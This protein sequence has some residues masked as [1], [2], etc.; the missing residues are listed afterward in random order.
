MKHPCLCFKHCFKHISWCD[1]FI[2]CI[3]RF[4]DDLV[5][6]HLRT[7]RVTPC[8]KRR[9]IHKLVLYTVNF[10][11]SIFLVLVF[12]YTL[13][14]RRKELSFN[15]EKKKLILKKNYKWHREFANAYNYK[16]SYKGKNIENSPNIV[17]LRDRDSML[18][19]I[20]NPIA[21]AWVFSDSFCSHFIGRGFPSRSNIWTKLRRNTAHYLAWFVKSRKLL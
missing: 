15:R 16:P 20:L 2:L 13:I 12:V 1:V 6:S 17:R 11:N 19:L 5:G 3:L 9:Q 8:K 14:C 21:N 10:S 7:G 4:F 18:K